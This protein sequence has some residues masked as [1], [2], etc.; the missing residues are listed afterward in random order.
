MGQRIEI[1]GSRV[2]GD[3]I[4]FTTSRGLT[5]A[6][7]EGYATADEASNESTFAAKLAS[8]LFESDDTITRVYVASNV[9]V[10]RAD[11]TWDSARISGATKVIEEFF[12]H[13]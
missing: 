7:G 13:Y 4:I 8:D 5:G 10:I 1:D 12:L 3:S 2:I 9:A 6:D 11:G